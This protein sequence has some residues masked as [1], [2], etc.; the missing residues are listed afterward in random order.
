[1]ITLRPSLSEL[2]RSQMVYR[3]MIRNGMYPNDQ[4]N[5]PGANESR[6]NARNNEMQ[7]QLGCPNFKSKLTSNRKHSFDT[8]SF[9]P[10]FL[11]RLFDWKLS[12]SKRLK[13]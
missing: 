8:F 13:K 3:E 2:V 4:A 9:Q 5:N 6:P 11:Q 7:L 1:M 12:F 10:Y